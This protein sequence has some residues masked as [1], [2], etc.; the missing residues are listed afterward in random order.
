MKALLLDDDDRIRGQS[1]V[2]LSVQR[3]QRQWC[4]QDPEHWWNATIAAVRELPE[5][6]RRAVRG[7]GLAGQMHGATLLDSHDRVLRPAILWNDGRSIAEC[8]QLESVEPQSR[9][10]TGNL[11]MPGFT[12]PKLLWVREHEPALFS[13]VATVLLPK[14]F[15]RLRMTGE[16]CSDMSDAA[17]TLWLNVGARRWSEEMLTACGLGLG[18]MPT[19]VE[20]TEMTGT[21]TADAAQKL[22][23]ERVAVAGG[24]GDNAA[25]A[26]GMGVTRPGDAFLSLGTSGVLFVATARFLPNTARAVHTFCHCLPDTWHQM[27]VMLSAASALDWVA[28]TTGYANVVTAVAAAQSRG[29]HPRTPIFLPYLSGERTPHNDP[30]ALGVFFGLSS[31]TQRADLVAAAL[32]G[33]CLA[34][35]D[36]FDALLD[37]GSAI[38]EIS[39]CGGGS[40][41]DFWAQL[42]AS[43]LN[44]PLQRRT[45][46]DVGAALG[47]ARLAR[48][49]AH[50]RIDGDSFTAPPTGRV[51]APDPALF[52]LLQS[53]RRHFTR[54]YAD[55][56]NSFK[57]VNA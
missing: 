17:G 9:Q 24:G 50:G 45:G 18:H 23:L 32:V 39:L 34:F 57:E 35:A 25:S 28:A 8:A 47:A 16:K 30:H 11:A 5:R 48:V 10:I 51:F 42:L 36:G 4:E 31:E 2:P 1:S 38:E 40:R 52:S 14:D 33:I 43:T 27:S 6:E 7:L 3:P 29:I 13:R 22:G 55:L 49:A 37:A 20:G 44:R 53:Q 26:A 12:A 56:K 54:I 41:L 21:L 15:V 46:A 19:L